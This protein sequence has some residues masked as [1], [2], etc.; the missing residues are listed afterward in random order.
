MFPNRNSLNI[1]YNCKYIH[2]KI[3]LSLRGEPGSYLVF[4]IVAKITVL[5]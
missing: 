2:V 4:T 3:S 1:L 5:R